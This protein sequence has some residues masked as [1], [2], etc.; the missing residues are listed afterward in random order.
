MNQQPTKASA[1]HN[2]NKYR[3]FFERE[4]DQD[5]EERKKLSQLPLKPVDDA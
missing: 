5:V 2:P 1:S 4:T 3:L